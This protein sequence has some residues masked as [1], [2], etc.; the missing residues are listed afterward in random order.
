ME[1]LNDDFSLEKYGLKVRLIN[2]ND[3]DFILSLRAN[4]NRTKHMITLDYNL[5]SQR[6][7]IQE[8]KKREK[9]GRDYYFIYTNAEGTPIGVNRASSVDFN[10][11]TS[12]SSSWITIEGLKSEPLKMLIIGNEIIFNLIGVETS[13]GEVKKDNY[14][15]IK[16]FKLFGYKLNNVNTEYCDFSLSK[17]DF[18]KACENSI[19]SRIISK[20]TRTYY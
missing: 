19:L 13:W 9:E 2:E 12:K 11:K 5:E 16:I 3:A 20:D 10:T 8:Y 7:W 14:R 4:P 6:K 15:A 1:K 17:R 18:F